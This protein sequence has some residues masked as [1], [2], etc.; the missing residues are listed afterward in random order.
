[1]FFGE[2]Q[3]TAWRQDSTWRGIQIACTEIVKDACIREFEKRMS[4][5]KHKE[6]ERFKSRRPSSSAKLLAIRKS[7]SFLPVRNH[8]FQSLMQ[9]CLLSLDAYRVY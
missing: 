2:T 9:C 4:D 6:I 1:M 5:A 8:A 3:D 7:S